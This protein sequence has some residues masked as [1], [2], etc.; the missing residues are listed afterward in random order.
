MEGERR[1]LSLSKKRYNKLK[2][3]L[4]RKRRKKSKKGDSDLSGTE[5][6]Q[7]Q[8]PQKQLRN[9]EGTP[10]VDR[11][12]VKLSQCQDI[13]DCSTLSHDLRQWDAVF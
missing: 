9:C 11:K 5:R 10:P 3:R 4:N 1:Q 7:Q 8:L 2:A 12:R 6:Q 13:D